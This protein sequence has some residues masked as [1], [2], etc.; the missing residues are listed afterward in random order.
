MANRLGSSLRSTFQD[1]L[2][3]LTAAA[4]RLEHASPERRVQMESHRLLS[5]WKRLQG[6]SPGSVLNRGF[7]ILRDDKGIPVTRRKGVP[8]GK[9]LEAEFSDGKLPLRSE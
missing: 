8:P 3:G 5:V 4:A 2:R 6:A 9:P 7:V 1:R